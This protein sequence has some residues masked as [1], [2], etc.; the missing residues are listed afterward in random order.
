MK[1]ASSRFV[2][3]LFA[4]VVF[5]LGVGV[6]YAYDDMPVPP[7]FPPG[8]A[9]PPKATEQLVSQEVGQQITKR[10]VAAAGSADSPLS[11]QQAKNAGWGFVAE[12]F[13]EMDRSGSGTVYLSDVLGFMSQRT[14]QNVMRMK[15]S[16]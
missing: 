9:P 10:F 2:Q 4:G 6:A 16:R 11:Q 13:S 5:S 8:W 7:A 15:S 14:P 1:N 3:T 12:H